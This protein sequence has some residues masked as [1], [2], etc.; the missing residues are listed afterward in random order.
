MFLATTGLSKFWDKNDEIIF[1]GAWCLRQDCRADWE[2]LKYRVLPSPWNDRQR[3]YNAARY[4]DRCYER[5]LIS[6]TDYLNELHGVSR[7]IRYWRILLGPWLMHFVHSLYDRYIHLQEALGRYP[8]CGTVSLDSKSFRTPSNTDEGIHWL[9]QDHYN[10]QLFS[11]LLAGMG[12]KYPAF[13]LGD[14]W[15][16][17]GEIAAAPILGQLLRSSGRSLLRIIEKGAQSLGGRSW[18]GLCDMNLPRGVLWALAVRSGF[19]V[20]PLAIKGG[21]D[22]KILH[23]QVDLRRADLVKLPVSDEFER[24]LLEILVQ[25]IPSLFLEGYNTARKAVSAQNLQ[26]PTAIVTDIGWY[27]NEPLKLFLAEASENAVRLIA[28]QH[29]AGYGTLRV[30]PNERHEINVS[31]KYF[32]WGWGKGESSEKLRNMPS[33][34]L[35][36]LRT[37]VRRKA[38]GKLLVLYMPT[39]DFPYLYRFHSRPVGSQWETYSECQLR[40]FSSL[41]SKLRAAT[42][43]RVQGGRWGQKT[44]G[45][46]FL[47]RICEQFPEVRPGNGQPFCQAMNE[48][49]MVVFDNLGTGFLETLIG[50]V[51]TI[52]FQN[53]NLWETR[54]EARP[55][56]EDL[57]RAGILW[58]S[59]ESAAAKVA[60]VYDDP[61]AWWTQPAVQEARNRFVERYAYASPD[62]SKQWASALKEEALLAGT[63]A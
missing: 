34:Q 33:P 49:R 6:L 39:C 55:Y 36:M 58:E 15:V 45:K 28:V 61:E 24:I 53:P 3:F 9:G 12:Y 47:T 2:S 17:S 30:M 56:L 27:L 50:D 41:P 20:V 1:L 22:A 51:P 5:L 48:S 44:F 29:G 38:R 62:W 4:A 26:T 46:T 25:N 43:F 59:P 23:P 16:E 60:E 10:L 32:V 31:D 63:V 35:S 37:K 13:V 21:G 11:Q 14:E 19:K 8:E 42:Q 40:F 54:D 57:R 52:L 18:V 7:T